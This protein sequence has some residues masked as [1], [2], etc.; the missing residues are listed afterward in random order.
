MCARCAAANGTWT[1]RRRSD[2]ED[3]TMIEV[4]FRSPGLTPLQLRLLRLLATILVDACGVA[5]CGRAESSTDVGK[6]KLLYTAGARL[7][8]SRA[9][10][11]RAQFC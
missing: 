7:G 6:L 4:L 3:V 8:C 5:V 9:R 11:E 1:A 2:V 10:G